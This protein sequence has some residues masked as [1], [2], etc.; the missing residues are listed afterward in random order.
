[1]K[2][3]IILEEVQSFDEGTKSKINLGSKKCVFA[4]SNL[5]YPHQSTTTR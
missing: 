2:C 3:A 4:L 1:M 5:K